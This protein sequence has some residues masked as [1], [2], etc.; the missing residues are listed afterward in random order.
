MK[1][2]CYKLHFG[3]FHRVQRRR[4]YRKF[5]DS[6]VEWSILRSFDKRLPVDDCV[7]LRIQ[8]HIGLWIASQFLQFLT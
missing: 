3:G 7:L 6:I 5:E 4:L 2:P 8:H 1:D